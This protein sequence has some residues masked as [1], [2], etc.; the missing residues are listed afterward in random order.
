M[1]KRCTR[2]VRLHVEA[3]EARCLFSASQAVLIDAGAASIPRPET[4]EAHALHREA[5]DAGREQAAVIGTTEETA[6]PQEIQNTATQP[7]SAAS[8][9]QSSATPERDDAS[10]NEHR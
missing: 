7:T 6:P 3:L 2:K 4:T 1:L 5:N 8:G 9:A 10:E